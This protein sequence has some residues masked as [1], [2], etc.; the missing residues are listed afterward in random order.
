[1]LWIPL[2]SGG[3][4]FSGLGGLNGSYSIWDPVLVSTGHMGK[5]SLHAVQA[6][7]FETGSPLVH[8]LDAR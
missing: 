5:A 4:L 1:M 7:C 6:G 8:Q 2:A 3:G